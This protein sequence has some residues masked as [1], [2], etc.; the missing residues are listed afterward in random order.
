VKG[1]VNYSPANTEQALS[2]QGVVLWI[3]V[4]DTDG[5][6]P[7]LA[8]KYLGGQIPDRGAFT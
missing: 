4:L 5:E 8:M 3:Y 7:S 1:T 6:R 2:P